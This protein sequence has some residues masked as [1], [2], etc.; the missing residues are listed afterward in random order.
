[1]PGLISLRRLREPA[2]LARPKPRI[3][4][5]RFEQRGMAALLDDAAVLH[6]HQSVHPRDGGQ[7]VRD[8]NALALAA[9][10]LHAVFADMVIKVG[11]AVPVFQR[12]DEVERL[13]LA[14]GV[15][16]LGFRRLGA[17]A[18]DIIPKPVSTK[19][20]FCRRQAGV[21]LPNAHFNMIHV[22]R[23]AV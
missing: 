6:H 22:L 13:R 23:S 21:E 9:G 20:Q 16:H 5:A 17:A 7:A 14:R 3:G 15:D 10:E 11:A 8:G 2:R 18:T 1:M 4:P 19:V 12:A